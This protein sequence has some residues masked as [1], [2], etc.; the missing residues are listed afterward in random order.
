MNTR[1]TISISEARKNIFEIATQLQQPAV[2]F[3]LTENGKPKAVLM[4][5]EE[6]ESWEETLAVMREFPNLKKD[7][8]EAEKQYTRGQYITLDQLLK[9]K[10]YEIS[11]RHTPKGTKRN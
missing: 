7:I 6:F 2:H 10:G 8:Q 1:T 4:G 3:T 9:K 5:A 11:P